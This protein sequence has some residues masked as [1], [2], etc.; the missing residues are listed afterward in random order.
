MS[1]YDGARFRFMYKLT[2][3]AGSSIWK[4][5]LVQ[6]ISVMQKFNNMGH[7]NEEQLRRKFT[8]SGFAWII[9][10]MSFFTLYALAA[11]G[12]TLG[13]IFPELLHHFNVPQAMIGLL[14]SIRT[15]T[16]D[17]TAGGFVILNILYFEHDKRMLCKWCFRLWW[18]YHWLI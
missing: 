4:G 18:H 6:L 5:S 1:V 12:N 3:I 16:F 14:G 17:L 8:D 2:S 15:A 11:N 13:V 7:E 10:A 9:S